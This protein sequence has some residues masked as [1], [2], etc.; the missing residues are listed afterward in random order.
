MQTKF[1]IKIKNQANLI[2]TQKPCRIE[3]KYQPSILHFDRKQISRISPKV[4]EPEKIYES[5]SQ[6]AESAMCFTTYL[7]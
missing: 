7:T 2:E 3:S 5:D 6:K 1:Y 4:V